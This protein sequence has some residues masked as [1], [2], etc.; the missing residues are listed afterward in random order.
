MSLG[1]FLFLSPGPADLGEGEISVGWA[2][3]LVPTQPKSS[4]SSRFPV[5]NPNQPT[6]L[7]RYVASSVCCQS[8]TRKWTRRRIKK[9]ERANAGERRGSPACVQRH[10]SGLVSGSGSDMSGQGELAASTARPLSGRACGC[11]LAS[12]RSHCSDRSPLHKQASI[13]DT[14]GAGTAARSS[15]MPTVRAVSRTPSSLPS[16]LR[17]FAFLACFLFSFF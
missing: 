4:G 12:W 13:S 11:A 8:D 9:R 16:F 10:R 1:F 6:S 7:P 17:S 14:R 2:P 3:R 15:N 5:N